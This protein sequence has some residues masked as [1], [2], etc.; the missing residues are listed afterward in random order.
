[1]CASLC[2]CEYM[3]VHIYVYVCV[4]CM[5]VCMYVCLYKK[6]YIMCVCVQSVFCMQVRVFL[7]PVPLC[8][9]TN[10]VVLPLVPSCTVLCHGV[11]MSVAL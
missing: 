3:H 11:S 7:S 5:Y 9:A 2:V 4:V 10:G 8:V 1:M 6:K